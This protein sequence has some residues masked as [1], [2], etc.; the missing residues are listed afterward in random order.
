MN[1]ILKQI[2]GWFI[3][4]TPRS[5]QEPEIRGVHFRLLS[6]IYRKPALYYEIEILRRVQ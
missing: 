4:N 3:N 5:V 2:Q 1:N 6:S